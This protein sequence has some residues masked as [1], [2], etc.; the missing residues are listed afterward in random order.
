MAYNLEES[1]TGTNSAYP[2]ISGTTLL[3]QSW[4]TTSAYDI[5]KVEL[6]LYRVGTPP[7]ITVTIEGVA[8][9]SPDYPDDSPLASVS[10]DVSGITTDSGGEWVACVFSSPA[11]LSDATQYF[12][13]IDDGYTD[14]SNRYIWLGDTSADNYAGGE[15]VRTINDRGSW[16][17]LNYEGTFKTYSGSVGTPVDITGT[18]DAVSGMTGTLSL[19]EYIGLTGTIDA[20]SGMTGTLTVAANW[21]TATLF[22][23]K[24]I[25][26]AG[27]DK[28][29]YEDI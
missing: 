29:Y 18:I 13:V 23:T 25:V 14:A 20:Q 6:L 22:A 7:N 11:S 24:R 5:S 1:Y 2:P 15:R 26:A 28:I 27:N 12:I 3:A 10:V 8:S 9:G 19:S 4:T 17:S 21:N 16:I